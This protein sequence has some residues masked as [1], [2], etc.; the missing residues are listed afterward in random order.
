MSVNRLKLILAAIVIL[1]MAILILW[2]PSHA[3]HVAVQKI[4]DQANHDVAAA[5]AASDSAAASAARAKDA[6]RDAQN[7]LPGSS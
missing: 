1:V 2:F 7:R 4:I 6:A 3:H 5:R